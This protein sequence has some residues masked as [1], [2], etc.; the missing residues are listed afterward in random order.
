MLLNVTVLETGEKLDVEFK[1]YPSA[2][3]IGVIHKQ[4]GTTIRCEAAMVPANRVPKDSEVPMGI[5]VM[6]LED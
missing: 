5:F 6:L 3:D 4:D 2:G 1:K